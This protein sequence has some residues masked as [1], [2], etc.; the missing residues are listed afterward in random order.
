MAFAITLNSGVLA[1]AGSSIG[2]GTVRVGYDCVM[3]SSE[4]GLYRTGANGSS[5][6]KDVKAVFV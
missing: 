5:L 6:I 3:T 1:R 4:T 2:S